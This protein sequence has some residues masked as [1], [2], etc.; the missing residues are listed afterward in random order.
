MLSEMSLKIIVLFSGGSCGYE[1][2]IPVSYCW[3]SHRAG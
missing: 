3:W 1:E 2:C